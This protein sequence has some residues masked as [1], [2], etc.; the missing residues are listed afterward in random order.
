MSNSFT[1]KMNKNIIFISMLKDTT[2]NGDAQ[3]YFINDC[4]NFNIKQEG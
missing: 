2:K 1:V 4:Q 3:F